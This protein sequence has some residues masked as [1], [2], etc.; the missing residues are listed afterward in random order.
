MASVKLGD[1][2]SQITEIC[3]FKMTE[4]VLSFKGAGM[5]ERAYSVQEEGES[6]TCSDS[7]VVRMERPNLRQTC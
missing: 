5:D 2:G 7:Q 4:K 6:R 1:I 3:E